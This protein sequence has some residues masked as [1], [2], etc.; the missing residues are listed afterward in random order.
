MIRGTCFILQQKAG[1]G[2]LYFNV[3]LHVDRQSMMLGDDDRD[4]HV[5]SSA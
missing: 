1:F 5:R 4:G 2:E 3:R